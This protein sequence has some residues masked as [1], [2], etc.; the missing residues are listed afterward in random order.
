[1]TARARAM[2]T[3]T[4]ESAKW[5]SGRRRERIV[6]TRPSGR[7]GKKAKLLCDHEGVATERQGHVMLPSSPGTAL[8][9]IE[10]QLPLQVLIDALGAPPLLENADHLLGAELPRDVYEREVRGLR[11]ALGPLDDQVLLDSVDSDTPASESGLKCVATSFAPGDATERFLRECLCNLGH[12][13][14]RTFP[15]ARVELRHRGV[16]MD[17]H[18]VRQPHP[19]EP[20]PELP[21]HPVR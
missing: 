8:E 3:E 20:G 9:V 19:S 11:L 6:P 12:L 10:S 7:E 1:M 17:R 5:R 2:R 15:T 21:D 16:A 13:L 18:R 14:G 4:K